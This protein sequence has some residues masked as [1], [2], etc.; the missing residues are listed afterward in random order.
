[1]FVGN[2]PL[3]SD[4]PD[5]TTHLG[6]DCCDYTKNM[7]RKNIKVFL[8]KNSIRKMCLCMCCTTTKSLL[9]TGKPGFEGSRT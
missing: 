9:L 1:M 2:Q 6:A 5:V 7:T 3:S 4:P 8:K